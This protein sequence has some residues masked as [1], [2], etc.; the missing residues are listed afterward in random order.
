M[1]PNPELLPTPLRRVLQWVTNDAALYADRD[2]RDL[3]R[4]DPLR[5][6]AFA[7]I[8]AGCLGVFWVGVSPAALAGAGALYLARMFAITGFYHRYFSHRAFRAGRVMQFLMAV[9]GCSAGQRG[10]L[11][12]AAHHRHHHQV[13]DTEADPHS[14]RGGMLNAHMLWFLRR[15]S[16]AVQDQRVPDWLRFPELRLLEKLDWLPFVALAPACYAAGALLARHA[17]GLGTNGPQMLVWGFFV[18]TVVLYHVTYAINSVAHRFGTRAYDTPDLSR[19]NALLALLTLGE[20]W[21]NNHH[22]F[23]R[24]ARQGFFWWQVDISYL[25]L[26]LLAMLGLVQGLRPVPAAVLAEGRNGAKP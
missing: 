18:S 8:H 16:F 1:N 2:A 9:A 26:R 11:W 15:Q 13:P 21:H 3:A 20:G 7:L 14:P 5:V 12:W 10:P 6:T 22:R 19:N 23:P 4:L 17:P 25:C 24:A